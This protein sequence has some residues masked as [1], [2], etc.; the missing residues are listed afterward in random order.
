MNWEFLDHNFWQTITTILAIFVAF[1]I[2]ILQTKIN[3]LI[4]KTQDAV[5]LY[6][7]Y[8]LGNPQLGEQILPYIHIQ[9]I[10]TRI[11]YLDKY[12]FNG[13]EYKTFS[14]IL[15]STY[16]QSLNNSYHIDLPTNGESH[17]SIE[18]FYHDQENRF[19]ITEI[20]ADLK[21]SF[22]DVQTLPRKL[23]KT[24]FTNENIGVGWQILGIIFSKEVLAA[25]ILIGGYILNAHFQREQEKFTRKIEAYE[26]SLT[27]IE[28]LINSQSADD[29][30]K[31]N[32]TVAILLLTAPDIV[33]KKISDDVIVN[34]ENVFGRDDFSKLQLILHEDIHGK[35]KVIDAEYFPFFSSNP[36]EQKVAE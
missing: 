15:P 20:T 12:V 29:I 17:V 35:S 10:G 31:L 27:Q 30:K 33:V 8:L 3:S 21:N 26:N 1:W 4:H 2:G 22:W 36:I 34:Q 19:W 14:R 16:S 18:V 25:L 32:S 5:E 9:N 13:K 7:S 11:I 28:L 6:A 24:N 23:E